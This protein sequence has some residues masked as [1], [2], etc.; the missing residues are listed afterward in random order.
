MTVN[1]KYTFRFYPTSLKELC[2]GPEDAG[3]TIIET[4][5]TFDDA[6]AFVK[7]N[8]NLFSGEEVDP[9]EI[10]LNSLAVAD[11]HGVMSFDLG[12]VVHWCEDVLQETED[13][14]DNDAWTL[15]PRT[16]APVSR[17]AA[18][19][20]AV[21]SNI[22]V[23]NDQFSNVNFESLRRQSFPDLF[24]EQDLQQG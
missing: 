19:L 2:N 3:L 23:E 1:P 11:A 5:L 4:E 9:Q 18:F 14:D 22:E 6:V 16:A 7:A 15:V 21:M 17:W 12:Y 13:E 24:K 8:Q 10:A 20:N